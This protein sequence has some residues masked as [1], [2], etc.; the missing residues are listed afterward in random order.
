MTKIVE[1]ASPSHDKLKAAL[2]SVVK[3]LESGTIYYDWN[4][5]ECCNVGVVAQTLLKKKQDEMAVML[6]EVH[7]E[8]AKSDSLD[9][10]GVDPSWNNII[11]ILC[12][13][14]GKPMYEVFKR[15]ESAG[16]SRE[17]IIHLEYL[18]NEEILRRSRIEK[19]EYKDVPGERTVTKKRPHSKRFLRW[20]GMEEAYLSTEP[21]L[22]SRFD[23]DERYWTDKNNLILYLKSW[24]DMIDL[25]ISWR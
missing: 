10:E 17:D 3:A 5:H 25:G 6:S 24:I 15:L 1:G 12:P 23:Y 8:A 9:T 13:T 19:V 14:T 21:E 4:H 20:L 11:G 7:A 18:N 22:R 2:V 16:L